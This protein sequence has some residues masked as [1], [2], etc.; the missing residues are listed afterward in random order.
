MKKLVLLVVFAFFV[1]AALFAQGKP[2]GELFGGYSR[3]RVIGENINGWNVSIAG[4]PGR[5]FGVVADFAGYYQDGGAIHSF[6][7]GPRFT[8][9]NIENQMVAPFAQVLVGAALATNGGSDSL[10]TVA[11]GGGLDFKLAPKLALRLPQAEFLMARDDGINTSAF[12]LS[13]GLVFH[14]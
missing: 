7:F 8:Y 9:R 10:F 11:F 2:K 14:F 1:P 12:R 3:V 4:N 6:M 5:Y 13:L